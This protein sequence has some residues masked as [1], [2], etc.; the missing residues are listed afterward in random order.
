MSSHSQYAACAKQRAANT[1]VAAALQ[2][3]APISSASSAHELAPVPYGSLVPGTE[4]ALHAMC[5]ATGSSQQST[6]STHSAPQLLPL[7]TSLVGVGVQTPTNPMGPSLPWPPGTQ[8]NPLLDNYESLALGSRLPGGSRALLLQS[9][10]NFSAGQVTRVVA[11]GVEN[12]Q[13]SV[14][15]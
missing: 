14:G 15:R 12:E 2:F 4:T 5:K 7:G 11:L 3:E 13:L 1:P 6:S 8:P 9:D 10:D